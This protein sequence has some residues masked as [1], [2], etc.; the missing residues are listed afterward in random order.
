MRI[1]IR[2]RIRNPDGKYVKYDNARV[3]L[4]QYTKYRYGT[5]HKDSGTRNNITLYP[6]IFLVTMPNDIKDIQIC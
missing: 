4:G 3:K 5:I 6:D 1:R 2:I